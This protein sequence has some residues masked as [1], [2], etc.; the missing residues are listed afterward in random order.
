VE[1]WIVYGYW[2]LF[3]AS[4]LAATILPL[5]SEAVL[6]GMLLAGFDAA[7]CVVVA[8]FGNW[9][10][11]MTSYYLGYLGKWDWIEK[12]LKIKRERL[13]RFKGKLDRYGYWLASLCWLPIVGDPLAVALGFVRSNPWMVALLMFVGKF[14]R[15]V[16]FAWL[17]VKGMA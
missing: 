12:Y 6:L 11:G 13:D 9:G 8:S 7:T 4:F 3:F 17:T 16:I 15:Y 1:E 14:I 10:G 5:G 2:G